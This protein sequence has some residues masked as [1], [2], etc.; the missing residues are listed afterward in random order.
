VIDTSSHS[1]K[2]VVLVNLGTPEAP[3][4]KA[5]RPWLRQFLSDYRVIEAPAWFWKPILNCIILP[6]RGKK[7]AA[8]YA[9]V[10][11]EKGSPIR[12]FSEQ[13]TE[14]LN[15][16]I[17]DAHVCLAMTYGGPSIS[18]VLTEL[19]SKGVESIKIVPMYAQY[20]A[21]TT[22]PVFDQV[23]EWCQKTRFCPS[24]QLV[25]HYYQLESYITALAN[26]VQ[27]YVEKVDKIVFSFHGLPEEYTQ[28][29]D[30][31]RSHCEATMQ[32]VVDKLGLKAE[33]YELCFQSRFGP[34]EWEKP[35]FVERL[36]QWPG[37]SV[38]KIAVIAPAFIA[39]CLET[40]E[41]INL[42]GREDFLES[43]GEEF[44]YIPCLNDSQAMVDVMKNVIETK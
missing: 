4:A 24:I 22:A 44:H 29:G 28:K 31:Y 36:S 19:N 6:I 27:P 2:A 7:S 15:D 40:L 11:T 32:S 12:V 10:W 21:T 38:K 37:E 33:Q 9:K 35:Y 42:D 3:T 41:E 34:K 13:L 39:D 17:D 1:K 30:P 43:G 5:V 20:S 18:D 8:N 14:K 26:T 25:S 16:Q 23:G